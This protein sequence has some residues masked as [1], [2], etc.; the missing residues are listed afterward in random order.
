VRR[1]TTCLAPNVSD[2]CRP[3]P[4]K[5][6]VRTQASCSHLHLHNCESASL[7]HFYETLCTGLATISFFCHGAV[8]HDSLSLS[9]LGT[10]YSVSRVLSGWLDRASSHLIDLHIARVGFSSFCI[11]I[12][13]RYIGVYRRFDTGTLEAMG[14]FLGGQARSVGRHKKCPNY[15]IYYNTPTISKFSRFPQMGYHIQLVC[16]NA[17]SCY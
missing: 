12:L 9:G 3:E 13:A 7:Q 14:W 2:C 11:L 5:F 16:S 1:N 17:L 6:H 15:P 4:R 10:R 8:L